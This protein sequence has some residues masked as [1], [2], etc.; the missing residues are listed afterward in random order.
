MAYAA[1][2]PQPEIVEPDK[3]RR[4]RSHWLYILVIIAVIAG[5]LVGQFMPDTVKSL[6]LATNL[7]SN[8]V[9]LI[10]MMIS[11][12]IFCTIVLGIGSVR[13]A[14]SVGKTAVIA[15]VYFLTMSTFALA[16]GLVVGNMVKPGDGLQVKA[17][18]AE[19]YVK[20]AEG[21]GSFVDQIIPKTIVSSLTSGYVLQAL[22]VAMLVGFALQ[23]MGHQG[24]PILRGIAHMQRLVFRILI[25]ILWVAPV[26][27]FGAIAGVVAVNR[28]GALGELLK[29]MLA[30]YATCVVFVFIILNLILYL[31]ARVS[32]FRL[33]KYLAREFLLILATSSSESALPNVMAKMEHAGVS[34]A[35]VG[36]VIPTGYSFNLDGTAI[37]LTMGSIFAADVMGKHLPIGEQVGLLLFMIVASKG[38][39]AVTGGGLATLAAGLQANRPELLDGVGVIVGI[40]R[41]MSEARALTNFA[42]NSVACVLVGKWTDTVDL[43]RLDDVLSGK[44]PF[45]YSTMTV[46]SHDVHLG[47]SPVNPAD[48]LT[49]TPQV[50][51]SQYKTH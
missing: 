29:V 17:G 11:P 38:A 40:D 46:D 27:A 23:R 33:Y 20:A 19:K 16:I 9:K 36:I 32:I 3:P 12:I 5:V 31:F 48:Q 43:Q 37:Y 44:D 35:T 25:M 28:I 8:F 2:A 6:D 47:H 21:S 22:F 18:G 4:D 41:F 14:L 24:E 51:V 7:G 30:F 39:A 42:G 45:D 15:L 1:P 13:A 26:G 10:T 34:K 49:P 50:D